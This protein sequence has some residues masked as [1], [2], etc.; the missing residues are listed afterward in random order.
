MAKCVTRKQIDML[1]VTTVCA[2]LTR[3]ESNSIHLKA[4]IAEKITNSQQ[5]L[6]TSKNTQ[7]QP[8]MA[9]K[10]QQKPA[11]ANN[12]QQEL[13]IAKK[14]STTANNSQTTVNNSQQQLVVQP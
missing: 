2:S 9:N 14:R 7:Q 8:T 1:I 11:T 10:S 12:G 4:S 3:S 5:Q 13:T 6:A